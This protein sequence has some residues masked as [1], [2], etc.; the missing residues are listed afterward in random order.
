MSDDTH[1]LLRDAAFAARANAYAPYTKFDAGAAVLDTNGTIHTGVLV[2]NI[3]LGLAMCAERVAL[4][5][6]T[7]SGARPAHIALAAPTTDGGL[8]HPCGACLQVTLE[9]G[10]PDVTVTALSDDPNNDITT[11]VAALLPQGPHRSNTGI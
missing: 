11:S 2:E 4:F 3:S 5:N 8:T 10:G 7:T 9:L 6:C 1:Q